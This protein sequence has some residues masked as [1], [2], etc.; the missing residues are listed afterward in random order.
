VDLVLCQSPRALRELE[1]FTK[2]SRGTALELDSIGVADFGGI[3][4][5][6]AQM[7]EDAP[8][9][10]AP[11]GVLIFAGSSSDICQPRKATTKNPLECICL[12]AL[13]RSSHIGRCISSTR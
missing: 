9:T 3:D 12:E 2:T 11:F 10:M 4:P 13:V 5:Y 8:R 6:S 7:E 1:I